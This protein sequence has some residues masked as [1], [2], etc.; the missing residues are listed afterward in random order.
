MYYFPNLKPAHCSM[1]SSIVSWPAYSV[2]RR[3]VGWPC[4][5]IFLRIFHSCDPHS[6][7]LWHSQWSRNRC[8]S[9]ILLCFLR[10]NGCWQFDLWLLCLFQIQL[11]HLEIHGSC[12]IGAWLG[13]FRALL[14][15]CTFLWIGMKTELF[16]S[17]GQCWVFQ[18]CWQ[19]MCSYMWFTG[20]RNNKQN[21]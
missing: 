7:R 10:S 18:I 11:E 21:S 6:Q 5:P 8:F 12:T 9:V 13:E 19:Y 20:E 2:H 4:I 17:D 15:Q 14:Y 1:S 3:Q 16:Q